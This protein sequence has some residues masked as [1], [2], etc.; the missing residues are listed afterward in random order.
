MIIA[1]QVNKNEW[2]FFCPNKWEFDKALKI[3]GKELKANLDIYSKSSFRASSL[4]I[5]LVKYV[6]SEK[7]IDFYN[8]NEKETMISSGNDNENGRK[9]R[10]E[11]SGDFSGGLLKAVNGI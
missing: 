6:L 3:V 9:L 5:E 1:V 7:G 11:S 4:D 8:E 2:D 10:V